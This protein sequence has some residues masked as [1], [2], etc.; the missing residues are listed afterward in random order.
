MVMSVEFVQNAFPRLTDEEMDLLKPFAS[1]E[2]FESGEEVFKAG[3][4][5]IDMFVV[6]AGLLEILNPHSENQVIVTHEPGQFSGDIDLLTRRPVNVSGRAK[7]ATHLMRIG[8]E[9]L[10]EVLHRMPRLSEILLNAFQIRRAMLEKAG[11]L[12]LKVLGYAQC[13]ETTEVREFL[14]KNF[15]PFTFYDVLTDDGKKVHIQLGSPP[16]LPAVECRDGSLLIRPT[17]HDIARGAGIWR[18]CPSGTVDFLVIGAGPAG[19]AAAVYAASEGLSTLV[20]DRLGPGGQAGG[21]SKI[22]NF[23]GFPSGLTGT[24]LATRGILQML[25]FGAQ[26]AAPV[27]VSKLALN[28][29]G[30]GI[31]VTM[32]CGAVVPSRVALISAGVKWKKLAAKNAHRYERNGVYYACTS[33]EAILHDKED[34]AVVGGGNSAGQAAMF[35]ANCCP[36]RR[37]HLIVRGELGPSMS[38]YLHTRI[39]VEKNI[40]VYEGTEITEV[41]GDHQIRKM[42]ITSKDKGTFD[43]PAGA[44]F[45]FIGAEPLHPWIPAEL[46]KD[47]KGFLL[48]GADALNS[49]AWPLKDR[50]PCALETSMPGVLAAGDIRS[51]TT[52]RVGFAVGDGSLAV[53][54]AHNILSTRSN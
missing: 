53:T 48:T 4:P 1:C 40:D 23:I 25:K 32:D 9:Q 29:S 28:E 24:E 15:V 16:N 35:L 37:V 7:G 31:D 34:V 27:A 5:D 36:S 22:E 50:V 6:R 13:S 39:M 42:T 44:V 52:K 11:R 47:D 46:A 12:G 18:H 41:H 10:R 30:N 45:V 21:S 14:H 26:L 2:H 3:Q 51:G 54:C 17:L 19:I 38:E 20:V 43:L 33:I 8:N 49:G